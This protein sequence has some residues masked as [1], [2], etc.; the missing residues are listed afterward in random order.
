[1]E[2]CIISYVRCI[3]YLYI[4]PLFYLFYLCKLQ[5]DNRDEEISDV[6]SLLTAVMNTMLKCMQMSTVCTKTISS[7]AK[8]MYHKS[9]TL[10]HTYGH[11]DSRQCIVT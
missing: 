10:H 4:L 7:S 8:Y 6:E 11:V 5:Y 1:M 3:Y 9:V 2:I